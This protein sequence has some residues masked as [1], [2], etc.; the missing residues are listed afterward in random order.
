MC[1][2]NGTPPSVQSDAGWRHLLASTTSSLA[3]KGTHHRFP[4]LVTHICP[5]PKF[6]LVRVGVGVDGKQFE[7][8]LLPTTL[9]VLVEI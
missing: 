3:R 7:A 9:F 5:F 1:V 6:P 4:L 2:L 8:P